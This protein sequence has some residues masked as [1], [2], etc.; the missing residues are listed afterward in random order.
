[1]TARVEFLPPCD[2]A[3]FPK[4]RLDHTTSLAPSGVRCGV[5][6]TLLVRKM[7]GQRWGF[8]SLFPPDLD[9]STLTSSSPN[10]VMNT[11][12]TID[13]RLYALQPEHH[14]QQPHFPAA[15]PPPLA[16]PKDEQQP[17]MTQP[18]PPRSH[19]VI[20][21]HHQYNGAPSGPPSVVID[22]ALL[23]RFRDAVCSPVFTFVFTSLS[24][25][26]LVYGLL[27]AS[28]HHTR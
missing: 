23:V 17:S 6:L 15:L 10:F 20:P 26:F 22:A 19:E 25:R 21:S 4:V 24:P 14:Q 2:D 12:D 28:N 9:P 11:I 16:A 3:S 7:D 13:P 18:P 1:M 5:K 27:F 8:A